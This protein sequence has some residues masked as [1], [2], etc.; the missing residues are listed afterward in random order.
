M[1]HLLPGHEAARAAR[2]RRQR[3]DF[4][5]HQRQRSARRMSASRHPDQPSGPPLTALQRLRARQGTDARGRIPRRPVAAAELPLSFGQEQLWFLE[6]LAPGTYNV[7]L[8]VRLDGPLDP[9]ALEVAIA[10]VVVRHESLRTRFVTTRGRPAQ[11]VEPAGSAPL[12][13]CDL[14]GTAPEH[15]HAELVRVAARAAAEPFSLEQGPL[16][17]ALL[18]RLGEQR[19]VLVTTFHHISVDAWSAGV[20]LRELAVLYPAV[21][22]G[23]AA[24]LEELAVQYADY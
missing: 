11:V 9:G 7:P 19:H 13:F 17:R 14:S 1:A 18:I 2:R 4:S 6:Q 20:F 3:D 5:S 16:L 21:L 12:A 23:E 22:A 8:A 15:R 10:A 24:G